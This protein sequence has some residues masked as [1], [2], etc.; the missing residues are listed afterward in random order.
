MYGV[1]QNMYVEKFMKNYRITKGR[2]CFRV[3][4]VDL[5]HSTVFETC[6]NWSFDL[7]SYGQLLSLFY[8]NITRENQ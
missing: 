5:S 1:I 3:H 8:K 2:L 4:H 6:K 7:R